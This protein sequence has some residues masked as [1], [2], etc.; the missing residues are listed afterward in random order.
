MST[1]IFQSKSSCCRTQLPNILF[2]HLPE[3]LPT[4]LFISLACGAYHFLFGHINKSGGGAL[5]AAQCPPYPGPYNMRYF[6]V[7]PVDNF[8]CILVAFF[9]TNLQEP[10]TFP[11]SGDF[12]ASLAAPVALTFVEPSRSGRSVALSFPLTLGV[13]YQTKGGGVGL[14]LFWLALILSGHHRFKRGAARIDQASAEASL[15]AVLI[16]YALPSA[17][18]FTMQDPMVTALWQ[19]F[20]LW[21]WAAKAGHLFF[22]PPSR[23]NTSGYWTVQATFIFTFI[24]SAISHIAALWVTGGSPELLKY[25]Y[26]PPI[27]P[28]ATTTLH[29]ATHVFFQWDAIFTFVSSLLGTLWFACNVKQVALIALW[30][31]VAS[32]VVGPGAAV[33]GVLLWREWRLNGVPEE[34]SKKL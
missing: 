27:S 2:L 15:F 32:V 20:P 29:L 24:M 23:Y 31:V 12:L 14:P 6:G 11:F 9:Q 5:L 30:D 7:G 8:L 22:R 28:P 18:L 26:V 4:F 1:L 3:L 10:S 19:F 17:L 13:L 33:S 16:G 34:T 21:M 25:L